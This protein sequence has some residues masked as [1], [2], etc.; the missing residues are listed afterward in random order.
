[1]SAAK[2]MRK[3]ISIKVQIMKS[4]AARSRY[5]CSSNSSS[6]S[7]SRSNNKEHSSNI[8]HGMLMYYVSH[9]CTEWTFSDIRD[10]VHFS[11]CYVYMYIYKFIYMLYA[12]RH[13]T[14]LRRSRS[15]SCSCLRL[16]THKKEKLQQK[17]LPPKTKNETKKFVCLR[18]A[19]FL[20]VRV[21]V[22]VCLFASAIKLKPVLF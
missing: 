12:P 10:L 17:N 7:N 13:W 8:C 21:C 18:L 5:N 4:L 1:M 14:E 9:R 3:I 20:G 11:I 16:R 15:S 6:Y 19:L 22:S 2:R